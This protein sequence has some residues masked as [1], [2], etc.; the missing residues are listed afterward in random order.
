MVQENIAAQAVVKAFSL[1]RRALGWFTVSNEQTRKK[2]SSATFCPAWW[3][4]SVNVSVLLLHLVVLAFGAYLAT[5]ATSHHRHLR[6]VRERVSGKSLQ[7]SRISCTSFP[8]SISRR[9]RSA[10]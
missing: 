3:S 10:I 2:I 7:H 4:A 5:R 8:E 9:P 6:D 1:Q